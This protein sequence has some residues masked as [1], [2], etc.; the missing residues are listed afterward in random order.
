MYEELV[1]V[2]VGFSCISIF[3]QLWQTYQSKL[4]RDLSPYFLATQ[5]TSEGLF[6]F[7]SYWNY[8]WMMFASAF[9]SCVVCI[10]ATTRLT[11]TSHDGTTFIFFLG[12]E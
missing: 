5:A 10:V 1:Y 2:G 12:H 3:P 6:L 4:V 8:Q 11:P 7:Y 9:F